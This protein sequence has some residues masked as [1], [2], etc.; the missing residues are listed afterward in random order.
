MSKHEN[1]TIWTLKTIHEYVKCAEGYLFVCIYTGTRRNGNM[2]A[3]ISYVLIHTYIHMYIYICIYIYIYICIY[4]C[5]YKRIYVTKTSQIINL[6]R[7]RNTPEVA[8][9]YTYR[10]EDRRS[11]RQWWTNGVA[12][13]GCAH[14]PTPWYSNPRTC[15]GCSS[16]RTCSRC[17]K[18]RTCSRC[19]NMF[20][21]FEHVWCPFQSIYLFEVL[22]YIYIYIYI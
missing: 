7:A 15:S 18:Q 11:R 14:P 3:F 19:S 8:T 22:I 6:P 9:C 1:K 5:M 13:M 20:G 12:R 2:Y 21:V 10:H 16:Q 17:L 4:I